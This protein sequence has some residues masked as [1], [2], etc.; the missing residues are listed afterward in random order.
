MITLRFRF[1]LS[2]ALVALAGLVARGAE[3]FDQTHAHFGEG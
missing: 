2:L 3:A 1:I